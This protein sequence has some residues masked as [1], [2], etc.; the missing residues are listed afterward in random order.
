MLGIYLNH[1]NIIKEEAYLNRKAANGWLV[2]Q[3][4][5]PF[6]QFKEAPTGPIRVSLD[7]ATPD[8]SFEQNNFF[9]LLFTKKIVKSKLALFYYYMDDPDLIE[10][11]PQRD[12]DRT[13][14]YYTTLSSRKISLFNVLILAWT[15][16]WGISS[17]LNKGIQ[18]KP[19]SRLF[20]LLLLLIICIPLAMKTR[21]NKISPV[22]STISQTMSKYFLQLTC[23]R[24]V[25]S[26]Q[27]RL[28]T[29]PP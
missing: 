16:F 26:K 9:H 6:Y 21:L 11:T 18:H 24:L 23:F 4:H 3:K 19:S 2:S 17:V 10:L 5:G 14:A 27:K 8:I 22:I 25:G 12:N 13:L 29:H 7:L 20:A 1:L 15:L 28:G